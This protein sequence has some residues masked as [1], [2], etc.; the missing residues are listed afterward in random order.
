M[1]QGPHQGAQKSTS[2]GIFDATILS[3]ISLEESAGGAATF[4]P[5]LSGAGCGCDHAGRAVKIKRRKQ[6]TKD[7]CIITSNFWKDEVNETNLL[8]N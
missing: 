6:Y 8:V 2:T 3:A 7:F 5:A 1:R 4:V